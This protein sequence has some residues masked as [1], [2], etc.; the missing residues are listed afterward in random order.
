[1]IT[2]DLV[3]YFMTFALFVYLTRKRR[4][5][6]LPLPPGPTK[7]PII[8]NLLD[9]PAR[10][11][12][13]TYHEWS[14]SFD[15][16]IIHLKI[17]GMSVIVLDTAEAAFELLE[18]RSSIYSG[19][20]RLPMLNELCGYSY[21]F[22][23][24]KYG[25]QW[26]EHRRLF[27]H[28]FHPT[29]SKLM[30]PNLLKATHGLLRRMLARPDIDF[31]DHLPHL[32]GETIVSIAY[33]L[34]VLPEN[35]PYIQAS[36]EGIQPVRASGLPGAFLVDTLPIL[37]YVPDW[38]PFTDFKRKAK[39]WREVAH[40]MVDVP[41]DAAMSQIRKGNAMP[42][43]LSRSLENMD[44]SQDLRHQEE[45]IKCV[46][47][48]MYTAG[49][50]TTISTIASCIL[51]FLA[52]PEALKK[53]QI[54]IDS[55]VAPGQLPDFKDQDSLPYVTAITMEALRWKEVTPLAIPHFL[56]V[57]D[58]Y[59]GYRLPAGSVVLP[60]AW[61][62]MHN[63]SVYPDPFT[64]DPDRFMKDGKLSPD[65]RDPALAAF[66]FG[67]RIC[68]GRY[69]AHDTVWIAIASIAATFDI[70]KA[71]DDSGNIIEPT[72]EYLT[73]LACRPLPFKCTIK[74]RSK[75]AEA[76]IRSTAIH[77]Y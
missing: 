27:H 28:A 34:D 41:F 14:K 15:S 53:A 45:V 30:H 9:M 67:R 6:D 55:F 16:D 47:G 58:E 57:D 61:A 24:M 44:D 8:G 25:D 59:K 40:K 70:T 52:N 19:R 1:M 39:A 31:L 21:N 11:E 37:K 68:P 76:L 63:E 64:F 26:R 66:G 71:T 22:G 35:D 56:E 36:E 7:L 73:G 62:I 43:F 3:A 72:Y 32:A 33:G 75:E 13:V 77:D 20:P 18:R 48:T 50:D 38:M 42:S 17:A 60:N 10:M 46:A 49:S 12:W 74:P 54:E 4:P 23:L 65:V 51:A 69:M 5:K 2:I 29:A